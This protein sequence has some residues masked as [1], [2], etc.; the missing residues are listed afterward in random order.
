MLPFQNHSVTGQGQGFK[1]KCQTPSNYE[2]ISPHGWVDWLAGWKPTCILVTLCGIKSCGTCGFSKEFLRNSN[3]RHEFY[4]SLA[5]RLI[6]QET[7][8][9]LHSVLKKDLRTFPQEQRERLVWVS[10]CLSAHLADC[11]QHFY[12]VLAKTVMWHS[13]KFF[14]RSSMKPINGWKRINAEHIF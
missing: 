14:L 13:V 11:A 12:D 10:V 2:G 3:A 7:T 1:T 9:S 4:S 6:S 5:Y 8:F